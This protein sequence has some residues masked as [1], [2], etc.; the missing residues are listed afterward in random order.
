MAL[1][2]YGR[3]ALAL[4]A[5]V[6]AGPPAVVTAAALEAYVFRRPS[7]PMGEAPCRWRPTSS[8]ALLTSLPRPTLRRSP[9]R[10]TAI[11]RDFDPPES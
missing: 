7:S 1:I 2:P 4:A 11:P 10:I 6:V 9:P 5:D 3:G 8:Q